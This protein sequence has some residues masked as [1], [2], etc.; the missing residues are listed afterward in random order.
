VVLTRVDDTESEPTFDD[1]ESEDPARG[2]EE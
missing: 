2:E 1:T